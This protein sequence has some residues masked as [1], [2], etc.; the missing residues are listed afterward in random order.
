M[1]LAAAD[2]AQKNSRALSHWELTNTTVAF[3]KRMQNTVLKHLV[4][5]CQK[6]ILE[7]LFVDT[8]EPTSTARNATSTN[9]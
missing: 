6:S 8:E 4:E 5:E 1:K 2:A 3:E 7:D 9:H